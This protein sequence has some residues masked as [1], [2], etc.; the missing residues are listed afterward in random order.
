MVNHALAEYAASI[1]EEV[2]AMVFGLADDDRLG[3]VLAL[4]EHGRMSFSEMKEKF[5]IGPSSLSGH[6]KV[7]QRGNMVHNFLGRHNGRVSSY[8]E[9]TELAESMLDS[10]VGIGLGENLRQDQSPSGDLYHGIKNDMAQLKMQVENA[11][12]ITQ[13][14]P[15]FV[16]YQAMP[17]ASALDHHGITNEDQHYG[18][19]RRG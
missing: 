17:A 8:Y 15:V 13:E 4:L 12:S 11:S 6:L 19:I 14:P 1:P 10:V 5:G 2:R 7:L 18:V 3:L 16:F 9:A